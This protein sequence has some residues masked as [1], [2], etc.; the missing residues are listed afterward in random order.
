[1]NKLPLPKAFLLTEPAWYSYKVQN[2]YSDIISFASAIPNHLRPLFIVSMEGHGAPIA[3]ERYVQIAMTVANDRRAEIIPTGLT[4]EGEW[5]GTETF[6]SYDNE[7]S[8]TDTSDGSIFDIADP[9]HQTKHQEYNYDQNIQ[10]PTETSFMSDVDMSEMFPYPY[11]MDAYPVRHSSEFQKHGA[12]VVTDFLDSP[13]LL[14]WHANIVGPATADGVKDFRTE[15]T[16]KRYPKFYNLQQRSSE[17]EVHPLTGTVSKFFTG[18]DTSPYG[19]IQRK[20]RV[21]G[22]VPEHTKG[23]KYRNFYVNRAPYGTE[24][25]PEGYVVTVL[26]RINRDTRAVDFVVTCDCKS[27]SFSGLQSHFDG[28]T[29]GRQNPF[30]C[31]HVM[32]LVNNSNNHKYL[33]LS[34]NSLNND[35]TD[36]SDPILKEALTWANPSVESE[37]IEDEALGDYEGEL[38]DLD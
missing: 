23:S 36:E 19:Y 37:P 3:S 15:L 17:C 38:P 9:Y 4:P 2:V 7:N 30:V 33:L 25:R 34:P 11:R 16:K 13:L 24:H 8:H 5:F 35:S 21:V 29:R 31:K 6:T 27:F 14:K 26:E 22:S 12:L 32:A 18:G 28:G 10:V 1:M 20:F